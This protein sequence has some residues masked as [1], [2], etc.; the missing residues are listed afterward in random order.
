MKNKNKFHLNP[1][2]GK[3]GICKSKGIRGCP[4]R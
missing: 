4:F 2:T 1:T 3:Y